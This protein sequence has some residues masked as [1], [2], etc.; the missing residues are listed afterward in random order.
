MDLSVF[1]IY[2]AP[3][4]VVLVLVLVSTSASLQAWLLLYEDNAFRQ[5]WRLFTTHL[6]HLHH[7]HLSM[8]VIAFVLISII[9]RRFVQG[10]LLINVM[11]I[12]A[13]FASLIPIML[14]QDYQFAGL[15][16]VLHGVVAFAGVTMFKQQHRLGIWVLAALVAKLV[17]DLVLADTTP[18]WL[19]AQ[20][21]Y[22]SH[23]GG[24]IGGVLAVPGL[25]RKPAEIISAAHTSQKAPQKTSQK[26]AQEKTKDKSEGKSEKS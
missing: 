17:A 18:G 24:A 22:L 2:L 20:V 10:R 1:R 7:M 14:A 16:G 23:L 21:A 26:K 25:R 9:F 19:G 8:N 6:V 11:L 13:L 3:V 5:P 15:S 4:I 12:S